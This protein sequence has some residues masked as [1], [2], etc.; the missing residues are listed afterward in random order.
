MQPSMRCQNAYDLTLRRRLFVA[1]MM[2]THLQSQQQLSQQYLCV[3]V[4]IQLL[5]YQSAV[6]C[7]NHYPS[8]VLSFICR[9]NSLACD[10]QPRTCVSR[11]AT[12][13]L[14]ASNH[15][16]C[17]PVN[18]PPLDTPIYFYRPSH[19]HVALSASVSMAILDLQHMYT[20]ISTKSTDTCNQVYSLYTWLYHWRRRILFGTHGQSRATVFGRRPQASVYNAVG[21]ITFQA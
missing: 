6:D 20:L 11:L 3:V 8:N 15:R 9:N 17:L 19:G 16:R 12:R 5:T 4:I 10:P 7:R 2:P 21:L 18:Q 1:Y 14:S 13:P